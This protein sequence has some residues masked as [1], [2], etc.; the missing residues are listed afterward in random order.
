MEHWHI[1][2]VRKVA[3]N[4]TLDCTIF[5]F[6]ESQNINLLLIF[7]NTGDEIKAAVHLI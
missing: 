7:I 1:K 5:L 6:P 2:Q 4:K 3:T